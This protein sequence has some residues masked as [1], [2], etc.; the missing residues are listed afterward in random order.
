LSAEP[1]IILASGPS[2]GMV[3]DLWREYWLSLGLPPDFQNFAEEVCGLPGAYDSPRG[4]LLL[5]LVT[6]EPAGTAAFR[7]IGAHS[8]EAKRLYVRPEYRGKR[9]GKALLERLVLEARLE[10]Y[11][12]MFGDTLKSMTAALDMYSQAGFAVVPAY[13]SMPTPDAIFLKLCL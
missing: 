9:I 5:A 1:Q 4:R 6:G 3:Q 11:R 10:G 13:S 2:I 12:E 7:P 8:C